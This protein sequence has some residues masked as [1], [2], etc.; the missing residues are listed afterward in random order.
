[1]PDM[2]P[3]GTVFGTDGDDVIDDTYVD[4]DGDMID[5]GDAIIPGHA[6]N[7]DLVVAGDG[8]D[9]VYAG[10]GDDTIYGGPGDDTING[11]DGNDIIYGDKDLGGTETVRE[12]FEWDK[13]PDPDDGGKID[14]GDRILNVTQNTGSV[15]VSFEKTYA[16][17]YKIDHD[18]TDVNQNIGGIDGGSE[19]VDSTS[20]FQSDLSDTSYGKASY[21]MG[22]DKPVDDVHFRVNDIDG[23]GKV[24]IKAYDASGNAVPVSFTYGDGLKA[25]GSDGVETKY[26]NSYGD[27]DSSKFST[28]VNIAGPV[29]K[30]TIEHSEGYYNSAVTITDVYFDVPGEAAVDGAGDD[31]LFGDNGDDEIYGGAGNDTLDG[32]DGNDEMYGGDGDD[33][34]IGGAGNDIAYGGDGNDIMDDVEG[35]SDDNPGED[36]YYGGSGDDE[37]W[38]GW[39]D[40]YI[41]GGIGNDT[42]GGEDGDDEM[43]GGEGD[44]TLRG[45]SG[46]DM[47]FGGDG[48]DRFSDGNGDD[49]AYGGDGEDVFY[50]GRGNDTLYGGM[51]SDTFFG[52]NG[53]D[54]IYGGDGP[55]TDGDGVGDETDTLDLTGGGWKDGEFKITYTSADREDGFVT[56]SDGST[57]TFEEIENIMPCFTPGTTIATPRGEMLVEDLREGDRII[58]RDNGIQE[59]RWIGH[60][61]MAGADL[62]KNPHLKPVLIKA[63][64]LGAGLPERDMLVSPNHRVLV[65]NDKT[66]LYFEEREVLASAKHLVGA[67]GIHRIDVMAT[68][69]IHF[70]FDQH[71]VVLSNGSWTESF[72]PG[73]HSLKGIGNSQRQEIF[74]LFPELRDREG[75]ENYTSARKSL[76]KHEAR[77]LAE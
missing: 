32:G 76:K 46:N 39:G 27:E 52:G 37:I 17:S 71:E 59:I 47:M 77:L 14:E 65:A 72:Q 73:D 42:L 55:D 22:F 51:D 58:T 29:S 10:E 30:I 62:V 67:Q 54:E 75:L 16:S 66:Q 5:S 61:K 41:E 70:M 20:G 13:L 4:T 64:S 60:K 8:N 57:L 74:E 7:D 25:V 56:Y 1:M 69:Y 68:T 53:G 33:R 44:D 19:T 12:S 9:V 40:D 49:V 6:P 35:E 43:Y 48:N 3:D 26:Q 23:S 28:L 36:S 21:K 11:G 2:K 34:I 31:V 45:G 38:T 15:N 63:G 24:I 50:A 18:Y